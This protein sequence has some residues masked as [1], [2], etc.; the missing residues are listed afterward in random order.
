M[1]SK[2]LIELL[3]DGQVHS[4]EALAEKLGVSRTAIW[5]QARRAMDDGVEIATIRGRGYQLMS[6]IDLL[7]RG[8][9][10][11]SLASARKEQIVLKVFDEVDSTN[12]EVVR[13]MAHG[14]NGV[15]VVIA[16][17]QTSGRGRRGR[18]WQS[19]RGENLYLSMGL[20]F[21]GGFAVLD[22]LSLVLGVA[23]ANALE[24]LGVPEVG[25]KWPNDIFQ[26][27]GKLGGILVE[28]QGELE[29][30]VVQ[31]IAGIGLNVHMSQADHVDQP[32]SSLVGACPG[33]A[34]SRNQIASSIIDAVIDA[35]SLFSDVGFADFR[36]PWQRRDIFMGKLLQSR[37]GDVQGVGCG[38]DETGNYQIRTQT[39]I[40]PVRA[41]EISLRVMP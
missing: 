26:P 22:G 24:R 12:A 33:I 34:W 14:V 30:G 38:I 25:L 27:D 15:P 18:V 39:G 41:G 9:I 28:L 19:P 2:A 11:D 20:T 3:S 23:V 4:G 10:L 16:D 8:M 6:R 13:L 31:V 36:E 35:V 21:H 29:E 7:D 5:K 32:W 37:G 40:V 1:K 17:G